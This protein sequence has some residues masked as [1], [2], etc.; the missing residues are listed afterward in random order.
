MTWA[1]ISRKAAIVLQNNTTA[2][3]NGDAQKQPRF[4]LLD[5]SYHA[6]GNDMGLE[7]EIEGKA[8]TALAKR[9]QQA[10]QLSGELLS[11]HCCVL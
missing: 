7:G 8:S 10:L 5:G 6:T 9:A 11:C 4:S 3:K 1:G 2:V